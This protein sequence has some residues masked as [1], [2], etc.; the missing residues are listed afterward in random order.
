MG[1]HGTGIAVPSPIGS[2]EPKLNRLPIARHLRGQVHL[3]TS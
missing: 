3:V 2:S 1:S